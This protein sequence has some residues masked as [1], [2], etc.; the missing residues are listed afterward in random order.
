MRKCIPSALPI[1]KP[2]RRTWQL[3]TFIHF[4][5]GDHM[6]GKNSSDVNGTEPIPRQTSADSKTRIGQNIS[7][8]GDIRGEGDLV[9]EGSVKGSVELEKYHLTVG[10]RGH[11]EAE[12]HA[13]SVTVSGRLNGNIFALDKVAITK[14]ADFN[15]E[16]KA[17]RISVEDGAY[18]KA[19]IELVKEP[20][21]KA[22]ATDKAGEPKNF[23]AAKEPTP[24]AGELDKGK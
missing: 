10:P 13:G 2:R 9:I 11:V 7:I 12:I 3:I 18:L 1:E 16:I 5:K 15:G 6:L 20:P 21:V 4:S 8:E 22:V 17:K 24:L 19:V 23:G 14:D